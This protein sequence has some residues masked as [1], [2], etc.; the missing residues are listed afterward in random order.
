MPSTIALSPNDNSV[1]GVGVGVGVIEGAGV[2]VGA[3]GVG[4]EGITSS[5]SI[6]PENI[7]TAA[8]TTIA[9]KPAMVFFFMSL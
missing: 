7:T 2:D 5:F 4:V 8:I 3:I 9:I 6:H 1:F